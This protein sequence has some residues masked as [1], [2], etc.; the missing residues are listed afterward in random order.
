MKTQ[1]TKE[2][3][4]ITNEKQVTK[5]QVWVQPNILYSPCNVQG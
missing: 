3:I 1:A 5:D 2:I 4:K